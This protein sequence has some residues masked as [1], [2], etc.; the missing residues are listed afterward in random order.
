MRKLLLFLIGFSLGSINPVT[1]QD[2]FEQPSP[3][4]NFPQLTENQDEMTPEELAQQQQEAEE[5]VDQVCAVCGGGMITVFVVTIIG[6]VLNI[7]LLI[8]VA[9]DAKNRS[10]DSAV[11]WMFLV[12]FTGLIGLL[13][14]IFSRPQGPLNQCPS[15]NGK[16][17]TASAK[18]PHCQNP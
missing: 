4:E 17:L 9:R 13:I 11:L 16:R 7:A 14:Y 2:G 5:A 12:M 8:W 1:A 10:M 18:C 3:N 15:C 6:V